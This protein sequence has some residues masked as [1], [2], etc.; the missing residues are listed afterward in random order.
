MV[1]KSDEFADN[2]VREE[3]DTRDQSRQQRMGA[4]VLSLWYIE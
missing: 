3:R 2:T 4:N 1:V